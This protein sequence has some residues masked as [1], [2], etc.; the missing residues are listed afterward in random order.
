[1][2]SRDF[3]PAKIP[4]YEKRIARLTEIHGFIEYRLYKIIKT[5]IWGITT[6]DSSMTQMLRYYKSV[7]SFRHGDRKFVVD[8]VKSVFPEGYFAE[9]AKEKWKAG[10]PYNWREKAEKKRMDDQLRRH[11][12]SS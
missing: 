3:N 1:M 7:K 11:L 10:N 8:C 12:K 4:E 9:R 2:L 6:S 5:M